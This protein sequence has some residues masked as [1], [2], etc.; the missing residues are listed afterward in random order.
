MLNSIDLQ[1]LKNT[2]F[3]HIL[4]EDHKLSIIVLI[5]L[6]ESPSKVVFELCKEGNR[7]YKSYYLE[8]VVREF[9][10]QKGLTNA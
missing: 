9:N 2:W 6:D 7:I 1:K 4:L 10:I 8:N 5:Y 3:K